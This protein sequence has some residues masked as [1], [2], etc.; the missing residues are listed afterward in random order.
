MRSY[1]RGHKPVVWVLA[2]L[3]IHV[4]QLVAMSAH[5]AKMLAPENTIAKVSI[6]EA[7]ES[8]AIAPCHGAPQGDIPH[9]QP[10]APINDPTSC[11]DNGCSL[12][13]CFSISAILYSYKS[14]FS[15][16]PLS[17]ALFETPIFLSQSRNPLYRPPILG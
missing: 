13:S 9:M 3:L 14:A 11:C 4:G 12:T 1:N 5:G 2:A 15:S 8:E 17:F 7:P 6:S 16:H 10:N